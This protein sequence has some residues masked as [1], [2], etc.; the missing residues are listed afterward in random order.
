MWDCHKNHKTIF[1]LNN[2]SSVRF[3]YQWQF[4]YRILVVKFFIMGF[5]RGEKH[6]ELISF[7]YDLQDWFHHV[8][9]LE[10][11]NWDSEICFKFITI[12][13]H[14][15]FC[16]WLWVNIESRIIVLGKYLDWM[17][18]WN[19][20]AKSEST[21][22]F[23]HLLRL[24]WRFEVSILGIRLGLYKSNKYVFIELI[25]IVWQKILKL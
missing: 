8:V 10:I 11:L 1:I 25:F 15:S 7:G 14:C 4:T 16:I 17:D 23:W 22:D 3:A 18:V 24:L 13:C 5:K 19:V 6:F 2:C 21:L 9:F 20:F 12:N